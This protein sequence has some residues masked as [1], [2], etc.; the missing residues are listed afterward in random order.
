M[1]TGQF[2]LADVDK[3]QATSGTGQFSL[4]DVDGVSAGGAQTPPPQQTPQPGA[5]SRFVSGA[6]DEAKN[7]VVQTAQG[8]GNT[9]KAVTAPPEDAQETAVHAIGG[10]AGLIAYRAANKV[11]DSAQN[12]VKAKKETFRQ[13]ATDFAKSAQ[14]LH[15]GNWRQGLSDVGSTIGHLTSLDPTSGP[16]VGERA[17]ELSE[18]ARPGGDLATPLG[19]TATDLGMAALDSDTA[20]ALPGKVGG[21]VS[22]FLSD[23]AAKKLYQAT[24]KPG[25]KS[26]TP[27]EVESMVKTGLENKI[28]ISKAGLEKLGGLVSDLNDKIAAEIKAGSDAGKTVN[29]YA[30]AGRLA[31]TADKFT[32]QVNPEADLN[33][34][35][36]SGNEFLRNQPNEI[37]ASDAQAMK[38]GTYQQLKGK[39]YGELKSATIESQKALARGLKEELV[40]QFPEI[41][42]LNAEEGKLLGLDDA[43]EDA[44]NR[45]RNR[46]VISLGG[47][48]L[49]GKNP[50]LAIA[51]E[52]LGLPAIQSRIAIAISQASKIPISQ[53]LSKVSAFAGAIGA[54]SSMENPQEW[55]KVQDSKGNKWDVHPSDLAMMQ[56]KDPGIQLVP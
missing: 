32:T 14:D 20:R 4:S 10:D 36:E 51:H 37:P 45:T 17:V 21:A 28:P 6:L 33:A 12:M 41:G 56:Q 55:V 29:K 46:N 18:G 49:A 7:A 34:V 26:Y 13:A 27:A 24:L 23:T 16:G 3:P 35:S 31:D 54:G 53:A 2:S 8:V 52:I 42:K 50:G 19:K 40:Q 9:I 5:L 47:K 44:V 30:V 38:Q 39:S 22:D 15:S 43:L 11:V 1:S 25:P 48:V